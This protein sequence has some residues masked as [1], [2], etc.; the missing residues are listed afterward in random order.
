MK[1]SVPFKL[2]T[3]TAILSMLEHTAAWAEL[4]GSTHPEQVTR[5]LTQQQPV[6]TAQAA[7][8]T[9]LPEKKSAPNLGPQAEKIKFLLNGVILKGNHV[10]STEQLRPLYQDKLH[11]QITVT[12][13]FTIVQGITNFYRNSGYILSRAVL[14]PQHV[15]GGTVEIQ[16]IEGFIDQVQISGNPQGAKCIAKVYG[17]KIK[18]CPPLQVSRMEKFLLIANEIPATEVKAVM[19]PSESKTGG[20]DLTLMTNNKLFTGFISYD[21]FGTRYI[22]PQQMTANI[23]MNSFITSGD[24]GSFTVTKTPKGNEL[25]FMDLNY[26]MVISDDGMRLALDASRARTH[27]LYVLRPTQTDGLTDSYSAVVSYPLIR[28]RTENLTLRSGFYYMDSAVTNDGEQLYSDH[29]RSIGVGMTYNFADRWS[30]SDLIT[31]DF[32]QGIPLFGYT[33]DKEPTAETSRPT[34]RAD[35]T[36]VSL[37]FIRMQAI[38]G[39]ISL[40]TA[41]TGQWSANPLLSS[42]QF[43]FGGSQMGRGYDSAEL[44]GDRGVGGSFELRYDLGINKFYLSSL[45]PYVFYDAGMTWNR[46]VL[47]GSVGQLS[48]TSTG[49]GVRFY[50]TKRLS[51]NFFWA[52]TLTKPVASEDVTWNR[53]QRPRVFFSVNASFN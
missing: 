35:Y 10:Y 38:K 28:S 11:K 1:T 7:K 20:A 29:I 19:S 51:G 46:K 13:L 31:A 32:K 14:P 17:E 2:A 25:V 26:N 27:P 3:V 9:A 24:A 40:Y 42:E 47:G 52:Q 18:Q 48:G 4:P 21:T 53:G 33:T 39:P 41:L 16:V 12:D 30:G 44:I 49:L 5:A 37:Q 6:P 15:K 43:A 8:P 22:G 36:K 45:Q 50:T 23:A 34:G